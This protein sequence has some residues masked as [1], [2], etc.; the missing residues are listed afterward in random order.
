VLRATF[1]LEPPDA[2]EALATVTST[3]IPVDPAGARPVVEQV[4]S[5]VSLTYPSANFGSDV[6][7]LVSAL[8]AGEWAELARVERCRLVDVTWPAELPGP[9]FDAGA[10]VQVGAIIK[11]SLGLAP[12]EAGATAAALARGGADL[13]KDDELQ[14]DQAS[15]PLEER[16]RAV[17]ASL[18]AGVRYAVN[19]TGPVD[20]LLARAERAV[21]LGA[22]AVMVNAFAQGLDSVRAL[23]SLELGVPILAHRAGAALWLRGLL[24]V[25]PHV[26]AELTRLC[27]ADYVLTSSFTG[28]MADSPADVRAQIDACHRPLGTSRR[29]TAVM[30]GGVT[31]ANAAAQ[32]EGAATNDGLMVLLGSG[33]Y[34]HPGGPEEAVRVTVEAVRR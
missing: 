29:S 15:S 10:G 8:L 21:A 12:T 25:A 33:A 28:K 19:V 2:A 5:T 31:P 18:P 30:G 7:L 13:V 26:L 4:G 14:A 22:T 23:R 20:G 34:D 17:A 1:E 9:A 11:P 32:V 27:G 6:T 3:G 16:V 24:G